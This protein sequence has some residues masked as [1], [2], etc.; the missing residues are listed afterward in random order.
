MGAWWI[1][2]Q[3]GLASWKDGRL[4][5]YPELAGGIVVRPLE[6]REGTVWVGLY[7][8]GKL[9]SV[10]SG[11]TRC[12]GEDGRFGAEVSSLYEDSAGNLWVGGLASLWRWKPEPPKLYR[13]PDPELTG[14]LGPRLEGC[15]Q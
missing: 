14:R 9:C 11:E 12:Y 2:T 13:L 8:P 5:H 1:A 3:R 10:H 4:T 6:D 7:G 15:W